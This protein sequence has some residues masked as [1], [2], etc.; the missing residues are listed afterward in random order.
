MIW[1]WKP[2][3][4]IDNPL[5]RTRRRRWRPKC[6]QFLRLDIRA[7]ARKCLLQ[8]DRDAYLRLAS[9]KDGQSAIVRLVTKGESIQLFYAWTG[10]SDKFLWTCCRVRV[11][12]TSCHYGGT[13]PWFRCPRC[14]ARR[15]VLFGFAKDG[16]FGCWNCMDLVYASQ[17]ERKM[18]RLWRRQAKL[19]ARLIEGYRRPKGMRWCTLAEIHRNL[20]DVHA[21]QERLFSDGARVLMRRR[22]WH[23]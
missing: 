11:E 2:S 15:A 17:D 4:R 23:V 13:R 14:D 9:H 18:C 12:R 10:G 8:P 16:R 3:V 7:L 5:D 20:D 21:R 19:E 22:G 1:D 6:E